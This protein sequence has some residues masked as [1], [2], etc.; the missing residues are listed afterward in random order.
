MK[1]M[2]VVMR[3]KKSNF[4]RRGHFDLY[5]ISIVYLS[6]PIAFPTASM[7]SGKDYTKEKAVHLYHPTGS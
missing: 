5:S 7:V 4:E 1:R 2:V 6:I 3:K